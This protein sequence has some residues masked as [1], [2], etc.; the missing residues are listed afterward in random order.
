MPK[1]IDALCTAPNKAFCALLAVA[2]T[3][4]PAGAT[5]P[6]GIRFTEPSEPTAA[7]PPNP[8]VEAPPLTP[9]ARGP[10]AAGSGVGREAG[11][12]SGEDPPAG[13]SPTD[14]SWVE[15]TAEAPVR[16][17]P[18]VCVSQSAVDLIDAGWRLTIDPDGTPR[19]TPPPT[20]DPT[21]GRW[22]SY[23]SARQSCDPNIDVQLK[24][25]ALAGSQITRAIS[26]RQMSYP[27]VDPIAA[28]NNPQK[29]GYGGVCTIDLFAFDL[30]RL[31]G[32]TYEQIKHLID[33][34]SHLSADTLFGAACRVIDTLFGDLQQ[35]LLQDLRSGRPSNPYQQFVN[36]LR[37]GYLV[38]RPSFAS[39][40]LS[41]RASPTTLPGIVTSRPLQV[42]YV[43]DRGYVYLADFGS[44]NLLVLRIS[45]TPL[46]PED[47][48]APPPA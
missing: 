37:V 31:L 13:D 25:A 32:S 47:A 5:P 16:L 24:Q 14:P 33:A 28:V 36:A 43:P 41:L 10:A 9:A 15:C 1:R 48:V 17:A 27:E 26:D 4:V 8:S 30:V 20:Y 7:G 44:G 45:P 46:A 40:G 38:P 42:A 2:L 21:A 12:T 23:D 6:L 35:Q 34:L 29:D 11:E 18:D 22:G 39:Y 19:W 3:G